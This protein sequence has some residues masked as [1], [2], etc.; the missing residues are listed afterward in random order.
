MTFWPIGVE[1][2]PM[3]SGDRGSIAGRVIHKIQK[4]VLDVTLL[5][6]KNYKVRIK[7]K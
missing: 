7:G 4:I 2:S 1:Y 6:G 5:K 3:N